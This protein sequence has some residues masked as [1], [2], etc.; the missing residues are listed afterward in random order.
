MCDV[1]DNDEDITPKGLF[2][3][4]KSCRRDITEAAMPVLEA[5]EKGTEVPR[6]AALGVWVSLRFTPSAPPMHRAIRLII[7]QRPI[8]PVQ[9]DPIVVC[10]SRTN[11]KN[12]LAPVEFRALSEMTESHDYSMQASM[13]LPPKNP[14]KQKW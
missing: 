5:V 6:Y 14:E 8:K 13:G 7:S 10:D 3:T 1:T 12:E 4:L 11:D 9:R 2:E